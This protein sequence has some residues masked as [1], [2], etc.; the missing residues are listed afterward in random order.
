MQRGGCT[1][2]IIFSRKGYDSASGGIPSPIF[3]DGS[4]CSLPIPSDEPPLLKD[5]RFEGQSIGRIVDQLRPDKGL[6][7]QGVHLDPDLDAGAR[8]RLRGW[9]PCFGQASGAQ[10]HLAKHAVGKGDLFLFFGWFREVTVIDHRCSYRSGAN[11]VHAIFGW[12]QVG[13]VHHP[14][15]DGKRPPKWTS[16]HPHVR[17]SHI[18][19]RTNNTLYVAT[20]QLHLPGFHFK[21]AGGGTFKRFS[22]K[23]QLTEPGQGRST[24]R[25]PSWIY[26]SQ[27]NPALSYHSDMRRWRKD[28]KGVILNTVGRGQEF[29]LDTK[30]YPDALKWVHGL[31]GYPASDGG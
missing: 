5:V 20:D 14:G 24:W 3:P 23:L 7:D 18:N 12:L 16:D 11:D 17:D 8:P 26:P 29:V 22:P 30:F 9:R 25:L 31:F 4:F 6:A 13:D 19:P 10:S 27:T 2:K 1:V 28:R 21:L 15:L